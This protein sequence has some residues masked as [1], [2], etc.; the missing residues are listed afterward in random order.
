MKGYQLKKYFISIMKKALGDQKEFAP[1]IE[2]HGERIFINLNKP[3]F[4]FLFDMYEKSH[5]KRYEYARSVIHPGDVIGDFACGT[6]YGSVILTQKAKKV[7]GADIDGIVIDY[8]RDL[9]KDVINLELIKMDLLD[10][11]FFSTFDCIISFETVEHFEEQNIINIFKKFYDALVKNGQLIISTP[12]MQ[13]KSEQALKM[14]FHKTFNIDENTIIGWLTNSG[15]VVD[16]ILY[17][18]YKSHVIR[19]TLVQ[20]D[21]MVCVSHKV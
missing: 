6:G 5:Y 16:S 13:Q 10:L 9:Y 20:K 14:G 8:I 17:Q 1:W 19:K 18:N 11:N 12:Y 21:F 7:I 3:N 15:F 2:D 4:Y